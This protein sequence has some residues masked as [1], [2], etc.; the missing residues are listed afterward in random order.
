MRAHAKAVV[1]AVVLLLPGA[2]HAVSVGIDLG[3]GWW[4]ENR[5]Q[6]DFHV[7][8]DQKLGK[9]VSVGIRPGVLLNFNGPVEVGVP[10]DAIFRFHIPHVYFD[11]MGGLAVLFG[12]SA[13]LRAH[14]AAGF[15]V[16]FAK[17]WAVGF[18]A[19]W[20]QNGAQLLVRFSFTF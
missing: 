13:P 20:L 15:G 2:A 10:V 5:G 3:G 14:V 19:G 9:Y 17:H 16:P 6:L 8:V 4:F 1:L 18:E 12:N 7:R 11:V